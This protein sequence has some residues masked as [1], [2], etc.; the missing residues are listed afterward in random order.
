MGFSVLWTEQSGHDIRG[1][2][3]VV[4]L[5]TA[6][7]LMN[8]SGEKVDFSFV[9]QSHSWDENNLFKLLLAVKCV[10]L[11]AATKDEW[12]QTVRERNIDLYLRLQ[13]VKI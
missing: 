7:E 9:R 13:S 12:T 4:L 11:K 5:G 10:Q 3:D 8:I 1:R 6:K 2:A